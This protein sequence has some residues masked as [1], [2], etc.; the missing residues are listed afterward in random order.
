MPC[1]HP[2][3][4]NQRRLLLQKLLETA[5]CLAKAAAAMPDGTPSSLAEPLRQSQKRLEQLLSAV[6][7]GPQL[8][9]GGWLQQHLLPAMSHL[10]DLMQQYYALPAVEAE[11]QL[12][13]A[14]AAAGRS[15][16]YLRCTNLG[17][18]GGPA[19]GQ[20]AGSMRCR[21]VWDGVRLARLALWV[22]GVDSQVLGTLVWHALC[23]PQLPYP[24]T[25]PACSACRAVWYCGTACSHAD[26]RQ[27][28]H[29]RVCKALGA[30]R[31][32]AKEAAA[33]AREASAVHEEAA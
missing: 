31:R 2:K 10:A 3:T 28:G 7:A 24:C 23:S 14:Q 4:C 19:A 15:C 18:E 21:C 12:A 32:A 29:R 17:G 9:A 6:S 26:W 8:V 5:G 13:L 16:A 20:G 1:A 33:A 30:A 27:G 11:R 22:A 25:P